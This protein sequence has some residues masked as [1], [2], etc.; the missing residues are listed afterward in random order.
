MSDL[1]EL[2]IMPAT[3]KLKTGAGNTGKSYG[4]LFITV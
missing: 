1:G 4:W 3:G 2:T